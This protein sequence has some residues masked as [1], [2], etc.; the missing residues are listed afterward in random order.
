MGGAPRLLRAPA[1][2]LRAFRHPLDFWGNTEEKRVRVNA[3]LDRLDYRG[4][5]VTSWFYEWEWDRAWQ[6]LLQTGRT[7]EAERLKV[8]FVDYA[9]VQ[10]VHD[11]LCLCPKL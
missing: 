10:V 1:S 7:E 3:H 2:I 6:Y 4:A 5:D 9:A 8:D 11:A